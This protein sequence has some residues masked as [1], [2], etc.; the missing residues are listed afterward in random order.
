MPKVLDELHT[1]H[2]FHTP[3]AVC[4]VRIWLGERAAPAVVL[5]ELPENKNT[6]VTNL[7]E[8]IAAEVL[9][10]YLPEWRE[11][12]GKVVWIEHYP[13]ERYLRRE[14][15]YDRVTFTSDRMAADWRAWRVT[16]H[17]TL[18]RLGTPSW[19]RLT[20]EEAERL[21]GEPLTDDVDLDLDV[22]DSLATRSWPGARR[23]R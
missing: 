2:G 18:R 11:D 19:A 10:R 7:V 12:A 3:G 23:R 20:R 17:R 8:Q 1:F 22:R 14:P 9:L 21:V 13:A 5:T 6:S 15:S 16:E 4:R